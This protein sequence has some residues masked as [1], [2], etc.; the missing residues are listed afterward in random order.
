MFV[1]VK[2]LHY[3]SKVMVETDKHLGFFFL[4]VTEPIATGSN[5][6]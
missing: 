6:G 4:L 2:S 3:V 1:F 5:A